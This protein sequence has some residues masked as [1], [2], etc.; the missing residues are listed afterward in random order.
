MLIEII[1]RSYTL[2]SKYKTT[3]P[4][5]VCTQECCMSVED[6]GR[7]A[8]LPVRE[9]PKD[10]LEKYND[11]A[12]P[13]KTRV[14]EIKH[15]LPRYL[16]LIWKFDF[17]THSSELSFSRLVPFD[18]TEW[19]ESELRLLEQFSKEF[20]L[21]CLA[22]YPFPS[23]GDSIDS[24]LIMFWRAGFEIEDL[25]EAWE[26]KKNKE[27][28]LHFRDLYFYSFNQQ[29]KSMLTNSFGD[30]KLFEVLRQWA[31]SPSVQNNFAS[32]IEEQLVL[33]NNLEE[34]DVSELNLLYEIIKAK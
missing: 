7:L 33:G 24:I 16:E 15:F 31:D 13:E 34:R 22:V 25:L 12:K 19:T 1:N 14:E 26:S 29:N 20:F 21:H 17:P 30:K 5:D 11:S 18:K 23:F 8:S 10:L 32:G 2:F 6:E 9:I 3:R 27:S 4:L 28:V